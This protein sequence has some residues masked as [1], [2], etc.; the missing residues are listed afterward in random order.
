MMS[1][2]GG[3]LTAMGWQ[4]E[5][6]WAAAR[7]WSGNTVRQL[8]VPAGPLQVEEG[9]EG[10]FVHNC[11]GRWNVVDDQ[12]GPLG[13][14]L[15]DGTGGMVS[16]RGPQELADPQG[17]LQSYAEAIELHSAVR[18]GG[19]RPPQA[20]ALHAVIGYWYSQL[21][22][23]GLVVMP[24]GTGKTETMLAVL[25]ACRP[26]RLLVLVPSVALREQIAAKFE[27]LGILQRQGVV[28]RDALRPCVGRMARRF[29]DAAE[30]KAFAA[31]CNVVVATP[32]VLHHCAPEARETLLS[33]F[34]HL[35]VDEAH[36]APASTWANVIRQFEDRKVLLFTATPFREDGK[37]IPGRTI[38]RYPLRQAQK[39]K[40]FTPIDYRAVLSLEDTD[41]TV[42]E[43]AVQRLRGDLS[44][45]FDHLL[46]ARVG[47]VRR[48]Q[49]VC[50]LYREVA[51]DLGPVALH[52]GL[53]AADRRR[54]L[55]GRERSCR[56]VVCVNMLGEGFDMPQLKVAAVHDLRKSL[57]PMIQF[58]GR[59]TR[60]EAA[61]SSRIG[62]ASV[63]VAR[64][65]ASALSPLRDLLKEDADW[66]VLLQ[67]ITEQSTVR[68]EE[69]SEFDESFSNGP[70]GVAVGVL[71]PKMSAVLHRAPSG[72]WNPQAAL[73]RYGEERVLGQSVATGADGRVAWFVVEHRTLVDWGAPQFLEQ[74]LYEL[75]VMYFDDER[76][77]LY[78]Y[79]S[80]KR[81]DYK[82]L[83]KAV[84]G[85]DSRPVKGLDTFR[86][87]AGL[88]RVVATNIGLLDSRDHFNR[89]SLLVGSDVFEALDAAARKNRSQTHI[90]ASGVDEGTKVT[91]CAALSGRF[92]SPRTATSLLA[93]MRWCD[94]QGTKIIDSSVDLEN[95]MAGFIIPVEQTERPPFPLL[96]LEWPW[97]WRAGLG[98]GPPVTYQERTHPVTDIGFRVDD[99]AP[100]GPLRFSLVSPSW[101]LPYSADFTD[102]G[103][104]YSPTGEDALVRYQRTLV[105]AADW[106]NRNKPH[107]YFTGDRILTPDDRLHAP[108]TDLPPFDLSLLT[109]LDWG[110]VD[111]TVESMKPERRPHSVQHYMYRYLSGQQ[112]F[113]ILLDDDGAHEVA[114][115]VGVTADDRDITITLVHCK[116]SHEPV[117]GHRVADL[118][119]VCG[120][121]ARGAKWR[122]Y[123]VE[124]LLRTLYERAVKWA[125]RHPGKS[126]YL[127]GSIDDLYRIRER[128][129][130]LLPHINTVIAQPGLSAAACSSEQQHLLAG[131]HSY[132][133]A[134][135]KG[136]FTVYCSA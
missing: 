73:G 121:A 123:G 125:A 1:G 4:T 59:F 105:P 66:N 126:P 49:Q 64:D 83:A 48:A 118:Y 133:R 53:S 3:E 104:V 81:G 112:H 30:A 6:L 5:P 85:E 62:T 16:W 43:L 40:Y 17:V 108:R 41:R 91:L 37:K 14:Q 2:A 24:T 88:D 51:A 67:D 100:E 15:P 8:L 34:S 135:T 45:G 129:P 19:L 99:F 114:D 136:T 54:A 33:E 56:V 87:F 116:Y 119:E 95:V 84:L 31:A 38:F 32:Q 42:A 90:I 76:R 92:W 72:E 69:L 13:A 28:S 52:D 77:L 132:A 60:G 50:E 18:D 10:S 78:I 113:D 27:S 11:F 106:I 101:K 74:V 61:A 94:E 12:A 115:L 36:H 29:N 44:E 89:F 102:Q 109:P 23:P 35:V 86:V 70:D 39:E 130:G 7:Q 75:V 25:V 122:E 57:S 97:Q 98:E 120:Q 107:L 26:E 117:P 79:G 65:P 47:T 71:E 128:A 127:I 22:E 68:G 80:H 96:G 131:A 63:F 82:E 111:I 21:P 134:L 9:P 124:A 103:L 55:E 93:W 20:G 110:G 58:I 46:M